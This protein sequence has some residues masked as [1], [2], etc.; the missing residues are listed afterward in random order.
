[1]V[2]AGWVRELDRHRLYFLLDAYDPR[3][4][5]HGSKDDA[6]VGLFASPPAA[7]VARVNASLLAA[8][9][10]AVGSDASEALSSSSDSA[11][12]RGCWSSPNSGTGCCLLRD[13]SREE[14]GQIWAALRGPP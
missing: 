1:M 5:L 6:E 14:T 11:G 10:E 7:R 12:A 8:R 2:V 13:L 4:L 3:P 9:G